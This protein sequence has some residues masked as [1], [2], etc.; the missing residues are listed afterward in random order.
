MKR[1]LDFIW[2][3]PIRAA[4]FLGREAPLILRIKLRMRGASQSIEN[5][6]ITSRARSGEGFR[7]IFWMPENRMY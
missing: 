3:S 7:G 1:T 2:M 6:Y 5:A 4:K